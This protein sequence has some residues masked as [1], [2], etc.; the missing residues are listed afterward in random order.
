MPQLVS[1]H[2]SATCVLSQVLDSIRNGFGNRNCRSH[3][4]V[5]L[6]WLRKA[7]GMRRLTYEE[8]VLSA[9]SYG[10]VGMLRIMRVRLPWL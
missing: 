5:F 6:Q 9:V 1:N 7:D 4:G 8:F 10:V 2:P 3:T